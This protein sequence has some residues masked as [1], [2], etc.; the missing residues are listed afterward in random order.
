MVTPAEGH[1]LGAP[2]TSCESKTDGVTYSSFSSSYSDTD[3]CVGGE[4]DHREREKE[5]EREG[6]GGRDSGRK[7]EKGKRGR[8]KDKKR[9]ERTEQNEWK[10]KKRKR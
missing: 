3:V 9:L 5:R 2:P 10:R 1:N 4:R 6:G 8:R 7:M